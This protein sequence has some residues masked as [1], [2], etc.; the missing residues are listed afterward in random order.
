MKMDMEDEQKD[1]N[2]ASKAFKEKVPLLLFIFVSHIFICRMFASMPENMFNWR[3]GE[4]WLW[5]I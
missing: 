3:K 1:I 5:Q 4:A 2:K